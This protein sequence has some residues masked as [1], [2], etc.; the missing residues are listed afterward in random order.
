MF[1]LDSRPQIK[2]YAKCFICISCI[3]PGLFTVILVGHF[4]LFHNVYLDE[5]ICF[6][7]CATLRVIMTATQFN[8]V[9]Y[10]GKMLV[11]FIRDPSA[12][13]LTKVSVRVSVQ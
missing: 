1:T 5:Q 10:E 2:Q 13:S 12:L 7:G 8:L 6:W 11:N 3:I 4:D 9:S